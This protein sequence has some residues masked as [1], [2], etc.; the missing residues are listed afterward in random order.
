MQIQAVLLGIGMLFM[1]VRVMPMFQAFVAIAGIYFLYVATKF[2]LF[3]PPTDIP[4]LRAARIKKHMGLA[5]V[6]LLLATPYFA[7]TT[8]YI[9]SEFTQEYLV[10]EEQPRQVILRVYGSNALCAELK[11]TAGGTSVLPGFRLV[12]LAESNAPRI[13]RE[14][15]SDLRPAEQ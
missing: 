9:A 11:E 13:T 8:G 12:S 1:V 15:L 5:M 7:A 2:L 10:L 3:P 4:V 14:K 6:T